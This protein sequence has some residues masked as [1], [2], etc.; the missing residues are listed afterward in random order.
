MQD[1]L[2]ARKNASPDKVFLIAGSD[3]VTFAQLDRLADDYAHSLQTQVSIKPGDR[4]AILLPAG[5]PQVAVLFALMR[6]NAIIVPLNTRLTAEELQWQVRNTA[7]CLI[8][9]ASENRAQAIQ[10]ADEGCQVLSVEEITQNMLTDV[11]PAA[12]AD[13]VDLDAAFAIVHTS[14]TSGQPKGAVLT[15]GNVF[16]SAL[17]SAYQI[18]HLPDDRWLCVLP[19]YHVGGLSIIIRAVLYGITVDLRTR[20]DVDEINRALTFTDTTLVS[21]VPTMLYRLLEARQQPWNPKL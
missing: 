9:C 14:G 21:L 3:S 6:L 20:F 13:Q 4:M 8:I 11:R 1:W 16:Y 19:L 12:L 5:I 18:G 10:F 15:Y 7:C 17:A 2:C